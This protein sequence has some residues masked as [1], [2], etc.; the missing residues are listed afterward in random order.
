MTLATFGLAGTS[1]AS[2]TVAG[3]IVALKSRKA[4]RGK[5]VSAIE[6]GLRKSGL[7]INDLII[8][9]KRRVDI[10]KL[11]KKLNCY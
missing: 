7:V 4:C 11:M 2:P 6:T 1:M 8:N 10:K 9:G 3:V 5:S